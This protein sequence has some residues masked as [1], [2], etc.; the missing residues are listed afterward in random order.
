MSVREHMLR[1][2]RVVGFYISMR[3]IQYTA[4]VTDIAI[5]HMRLVTQ[6]TRSTEFR[7]VDSARFDTHVKIHIHHPPYLDMCQGMISR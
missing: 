6:L 2:P 3:L 5:V 7:Y 1:I 4:R